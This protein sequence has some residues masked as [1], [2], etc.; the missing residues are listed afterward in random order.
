MQSI[1]CH[2]EYRQKCIVPSY[3]SAQYNT[4]YYSNLL[5]TVIATRCVNLPASHPV[6]LRQVRKGSRGSSKGQRLLRTAVAK[7]KAAKHNNNNK[8]LTTT[9]S[10]CRVSFRVCC[11][12]ATFSAVGEEGI[13]WGKKCR[14]TVKKKR[15]KKQN[16]TKLTHKHT[17]GSCPCLCRRSRRCLCSQIYCCCLVTSKTDT[18][19]LQ[20]NLCVYTLKEENE[21]SWAGRP[22]QTQ[23]HRH[24]HTH[25]LVDKSYMAR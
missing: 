19:Q 2:T 23:T 21:L 24:S 12:Q 20:E 3:R 18:H 10:S 4:S 17:H 9:N 1:C 16:F 6:D 11:H 25:L 7:A 15:K 14:R 8:L 13:K 5:V 22:M